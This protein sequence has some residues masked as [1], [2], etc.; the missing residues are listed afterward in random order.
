[1]SSSKEYLERNFAMEMRPLAKR[2][3]LP[4]GGAAFAGMP[5]RTS[6]A[7]SPP[8]P[9]QP[10]APTDVPAAVARLRSDCA[11]DFDPAYVGALPC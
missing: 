9:D 1:M 8:V 3:T 11:N 6:L 5:S 7:Q 4:A 2:R 10:L